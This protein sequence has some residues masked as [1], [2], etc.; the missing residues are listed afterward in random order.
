MILRENVVGYVDKGVHP[1]KS[2]DQSHADEI[3]EMQCNMC[4]S[5]GKK[6]GWLSKTGG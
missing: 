3:F 1:Y 5:Y 2:D 4:Q 6:G